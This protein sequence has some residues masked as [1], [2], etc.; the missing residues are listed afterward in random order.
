MRITQHSS[1]KQDIL[2]LLQKE[3]QKTAQELAEALEISPQ[4]IRR[5]FKELEDAGLIEHEQ[6]QIGMGRPQNLYKLSNKGRD[7]LPNRYGEFAVS[8]LDTLSETV[9]KEQ[10]STILKKQWQRKAQEYRK[11][12]GKGSLETRVAKLV[13]MRQAEGYM[14]EWH[15]LKP[16]DTN[17]DTGTRYVI[18]EHHCAISQV[19][20]SFPSVCAHELEMFA[21][22][23]D[24]CCVER[25]HWINDG[26]HQCGYLVYQ[27]TE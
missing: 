1:T 4:A 23:L 17:G 6:V 9:D 7:R 8:L 22:A 26:E 10:L 27:L 19:A 11:R 15:T 14:A 12:L 21:T 18:L 2:Q 20:Q 24:N 3:R 16:E 5:H 25:T 13:Q